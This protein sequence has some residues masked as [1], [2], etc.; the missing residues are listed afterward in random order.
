MVKIFI[1]SLGALFILACGHVEGTIQKAERSLI[2]FSGNLENVSIK[3]DDREP[4][5]P[6]YGKHYQLSP[7][8][9]L[10]TAYRDGALVLNKIIF[11]DN[12]VTMEIS[13]P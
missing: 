8:K 7:G 11:L 2:V 5:V 4:F 9:H 10:L 3:I 1:L 12:Q 6:S 13:I